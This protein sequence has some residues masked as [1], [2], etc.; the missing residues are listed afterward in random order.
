MTATTAAE[1]VS[2]EGTRKERTRPSS[3][4][5]TAATLRVSPER[6]RYVKTAGSWCQTA[7]ARIEAM[8]SVSPDASIFPYVEKR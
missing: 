3:S 1:L 8:I 7:E 6:T 4:H 5:Q 2:P